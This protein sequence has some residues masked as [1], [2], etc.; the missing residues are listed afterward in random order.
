MQNTATFNQPDNEIQELKMNE[1]D[2]PAKDITVS[3][4]G[5]FVDEATK[6]KNRSDLSKKSILQGN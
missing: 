2:G 4:S 3:L 5:V 6:Q 1:S